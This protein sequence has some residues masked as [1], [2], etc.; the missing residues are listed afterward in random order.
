MMVACKRDLFQL[1]G[2]FFYIKQLK[3]EK[4][5][6][7]WNATA[8]NDDLFL[9]LTG[10]ISGKNSIDDTIL[11]L[12]NCSLCST[13]II[14]KNLNVYVMLSLKILFLLTFDLIPICKCFF[15]FMEQSVRQVKLRLWL[16]AG[17][18]VFPFFFPT[19]RKRAST[20]NQ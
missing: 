17:N 4:F 11:E 5:L 1:G 19:N 3:R 9:S 7:G 10:E 13:M 6:L 16:T 14:S 20:L 2:R 15:L 12:N 18:D 8:G